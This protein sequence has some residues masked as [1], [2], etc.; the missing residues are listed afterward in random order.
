MGENLY[1]SD[2]SQ[3]MP[4]LGEQQRETEFGRQFLMGQDTTKNAQRDAD[5]AQK[6]ANIQSGAALAG[7]AFTGGASLA[8]MPKS[9]PAGVDP[10]MQQRYN[11][12]TID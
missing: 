12:A 1:R 2:L 9:A 8:A 3:V 5:A 6:M 4:I 7:A 11:N 10:E